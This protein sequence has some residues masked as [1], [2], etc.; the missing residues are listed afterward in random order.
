[1]ISA[2]RLIDNRAF[3]GLFVTGKQSFGDE[4][5]NAERTEE[6]KP[7]RRYLDLVQDRFCNQMQHGK[8]TYVTYSPVGTALHLTP[9]NKGPELV[10]VS[11]TTT[12]QL[13]CWTH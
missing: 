12:D 9:V 1:V 2:I 5:C 8:A 13:L 6:A 7:A 10:A 4:F 3:R 11:I